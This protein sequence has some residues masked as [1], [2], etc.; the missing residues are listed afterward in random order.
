M[1]ASSYVTQLNLI[2]V[3]M[4]TTYLALIAAVAATVS[5]TAGA[6]SGRTDEARAEA[7][8]RIA[9]AEHAASLRAFEPRQTEKVVVSD[10]DSAR[11]AAAQATD[12]RSHESHLA[13][14]LRAGAGV[15]PAQIAVTDTDSAR[16]AAG[17]RVRQES[18]LADFAA[19]TEMQ[20][21]TAIASNR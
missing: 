14:V 7:G 1:N 12:R 18:L 4:K 17:Q 3:I 10:S 2:G 6:V 15:K 16:A 21:E 5:M 13:S 19:Y 20:S 8:A 11:R 9:A